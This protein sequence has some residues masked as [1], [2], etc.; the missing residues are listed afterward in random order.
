MGYERKNIN[1]MQGYQYGEQAQGADI[2]KLNTNENP[3]PPS[4][5]VALALKSFDATTLRRYPNPNADEFCALV[6][7]LHK[8]EPNKIIATNGGDE[9][10][11]L[12]ITT[13]VEP[14]AVVGRPD[15]DYSLHSTLAEIQNS[16]LYSIPLLQNWELPEDFSA[17]MNA[18][19]A[20]LTFVTNPQTPSGKL[21]SLSKIRKLVASLNGVL[22]LDQTY[23]DFADDKHKQ[24]SID[25]INEF[26]NV[27]ILRSLSKSYSLAGLRIGYALGAAQLIQPMRT[28]TK[29]SYNLNSITQNLACAALSSQEYMQEI[30][31]K[32]KIS[33]EDLSQSLTAIGWK[34]TPSQSNF[35]L[36]ET[37]EKIPKSAENI[38]S[39]L[40]QKNI[41]VRYF[42]QPRTRNALRISVGTQQEN[43]RLLVALKEICAG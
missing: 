4:P 1:S 43:Q 5:K 23:V 30:W 12:A 2:L 14:H 19:Q 37:T 22:L 20:S 27:L 33:R 6:A 9:L 25:L 15:P 17:K 32:I 41:L 42:D 26:E 40:R 36:A 3:Y 10:L 34:I 11:R 29:D 7:K 38:Y 16:R 28:K 35:L 13:F 24:S 8:I 39:E 21:L 18:A 31:E